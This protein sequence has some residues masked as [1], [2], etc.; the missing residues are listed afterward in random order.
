MF[1]FNRYKYSDIK[2]I[3]LKKPPHDKWNRLS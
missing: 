3:E 1:L 2:P